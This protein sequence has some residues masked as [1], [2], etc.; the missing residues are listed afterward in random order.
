M[1]VAVGVMSRG[2]N[3]VRRRDRGARGAHGDR[4]G[5]REERGE[6]AVAKVVHLPAIGHPTPLFELM[7][8][9]WTRTG[10]CLQRALGIILNGMGDNCA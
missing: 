4:D 9:G 7:P 5:R 1:S 10:G 8:A 6:K 2:V 3:V